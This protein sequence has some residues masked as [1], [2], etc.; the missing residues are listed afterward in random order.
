MMAGLNEG[1]YTTCVVYV[2]GPFV[3]HTSMQGLGPEVLAWWDYGY[4]I[5]G[6]AKRTSVADGNTWN[7]EHIETWTTVTHLSEPYIVHQFPKGLGRLSFLLA[8][9]LW[10]GLPAAAR[11]RSAA[12]CPTR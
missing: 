5:T 6:I 11:P 2:R 12:F 4:Q 1:E 9:C 10:S 7:H 3:D 8:P